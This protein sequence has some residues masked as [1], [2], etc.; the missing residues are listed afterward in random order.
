M[1]VALIWM[2]KKVKKVIISK[3][4]SIEDRTIWEPNDGELSIKKLNDLL[5]LL[6]IQLLQLWIVIDASQVNKKMTKDANDHSHYE[7][8]SQHASE[9]LTRGRNGQRPE[10]LMF[11][12]LVFL[13]I[14]ICCK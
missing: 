13:I 14:S 4:V 8:S 9:D 11:F 5:I 3:W 12:L 1:R 10:H 2:Q 7:K 6:L